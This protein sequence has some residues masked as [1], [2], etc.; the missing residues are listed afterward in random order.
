M[1]GKRRK[2]PATKLRDRS[3]SRKRLEKNDTNKLS[4]AAPNKLRSN[5]WQMRIA[6]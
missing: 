6:S 2:K 5:K 4:T 1:I 3:K